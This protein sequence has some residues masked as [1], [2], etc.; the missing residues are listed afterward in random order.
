MAQ[1][2]DQRPCWFVGA[3][4]GEYG[5]QTERFLEEGIW[6]HGHKDKHLDQ[7]RSMRLGDRIAIKSW[8]TRKSDLPFEN[9]SKR[10]SVMG[11]KAVGTVTENPGDGRRVRVDWTRVDPAREWY[12]YSY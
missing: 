2:S 5:D 9:L 7:V 11:I 3:V 10:I 12:F 4:I 8:Y 6:E 1:L